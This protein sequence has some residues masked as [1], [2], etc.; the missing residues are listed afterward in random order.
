MPPIFLTLFNSDTYSQRKVAFDQD[1]GYEYTLLEPQDFWK[2]VPN[3]VKPI[4]HFFNAPISAGADDDM[5]PLRFIKEIATE[6][7]FVAFKLDVDTPVVEIPQAM[8]ILQD[9]QVNKLIDEFF[10]E[11]HFRCE[12]MM[13]C[14][15]GTG[16]PLEYAGLKLDRVH[17]MGY[18][19]D[20]RKLGIRAHIWP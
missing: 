9:P 5:S 6:D 17:A 7:D 3:R 13:Y 18:F 1:Y 20:L 16:M 15:W 10:F 11:L 12:I 2:R 8:A 19:R 14:G 4:Y